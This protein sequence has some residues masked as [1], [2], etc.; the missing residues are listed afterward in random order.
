MCIRDRTRDE[1]PINQADRIITVEEPG[2]YQLT[3]QNN[4]TGC[5][6][7]ETIEVSEKSS[8]EGI[9]F[10]NSTSLDCRDSIRTVSISQS[11]DIDDELSFEWGTLNGN[12]LSPTTNPEITVNRAGTYIITIRSSLTGCV[13]EDSVVLSLIHISEPTRPY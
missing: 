13:L 6:A 9:E 12:F 2:I 10:P 1:A 5:E 7:S 8:I 3:I 4:N 11:D